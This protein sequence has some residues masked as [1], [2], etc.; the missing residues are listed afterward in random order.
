MTKEAARIPCNRRI[1]SYTYVTKYT[2]GLAKVLAFRMY[3][4]LDFSILLVL[5]GS[6]IYSDYCVSSCQVGEKKTGPISHF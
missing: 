4:P 2:P 5:H 3:I 1:F 6:P